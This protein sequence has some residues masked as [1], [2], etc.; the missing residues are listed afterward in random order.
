MRTLAATSRVGTMREYFG[1][2]P[3]AGYFGGLGPSDTGFTNMYSCDPAGSPFGMARGLPDTAA[4]PGEDRFGAR[5]WINREARKRMT[6]FA[7]AYATSGEIPL[8][9]LPWFDIAEQYAPWDRRVGYRSIFHELEDRGERY[10]CCAWPDTNLLEDHRDEALARRTIDRSSADDRLVFLHLQELDALG[11]AYGP[12]SSELL[13]AIRRADE[14]VRDVVTALRSRVDRLDVILFSDHG[15]V[16]VTGTVDVWSAVT[17]TGC[18]PGRDVV[19]FLDSTMARFWFPTD[20]ARGAIE[21]VLAA[22]PGNVLD[23]RERRRLD[24]DGCDPRNGELFFLASPGHVI[25]PNFFQANADHTRGMHG[26]EPDC[27]DNMGIVLVSDVD[28]DAPA[29]MGIVGPAAIY[30]ALRHSLGLGREGVRTRVVTA[31]PSQRAFT[32]HPDPRAAATVQ[33]HMRRIVDE[34]LRVIPSPTA[35]VLSG[36]FGRDEGGVRRDPDG[37]FIPVNDYD[38]LVIAPD[39]TAPGMEA[40]QTV[41]HTLAREFRT[42]FVHFSVWPD[43]ALA[44]APSMANFDLRHGSRIIHGASDVL[45]GLADMSAADIPESDGLQLLYNRLGGILTGLKAPHDAGGRLTQ[46]E[47]GYLTNQI[48]KARIALGDWRLVRA[49]AYDVSYRKRRERFLW[50]APGLSVAGRE[51]DAILAGYD[52]KLHPERSAMD[53]PGAAAVEAANWLVAAIIDATGAMTRRPVETPA[54][55]SALYREIMRV[56]DDVVRRDN[57]HAIR[58]LQGNAHVQVRPDASEWVRSAIYASFPLVAV[59]ASGD[60]EAFGRACERLDTCLTPPWPRP[61]TPDNWEVVRSRLSHA[62]LALVG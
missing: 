23:A 45:N 4:E 25:I 52:F 16:P 60:D 54:D 43:L 41:G 40:M 15:M 50:L 24:I 46:H 35:I 47:R 3:R 57:E 48:M 31:G 51:R 6:P 11:H 17:S 37:T 27:P 36:S 62:W 32:Q 26:C 21:R 14:Y 34:T 53:N 58:Q 38:L 33:G 5:A 12:E 56:A 29:D 13:T 9:L 1:F 49:R 59:A 20:V 44:A 30:E 18:V 8:S 39:A 7:A 55:A 42:D 61:L 28:T 10:F 2:L 19:F 22:L